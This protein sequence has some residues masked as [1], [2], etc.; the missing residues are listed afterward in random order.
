VETSPEPAE[1]V[2]R[3]SIGRELRRRE[4]KVRRD[5]T[6]I[7]EIAHDLTA[8]S[9]ENQISRLSQGFFAWYRKLIELGA[10]E[11]TAQD[12]VTGLAREWRGVADPSIDD[13]L[14]PLLERFLEGIRMGGTIERREG[15][16][17]RVI[18]VGPPGC[19]KSTTLAK[20]ASEFS[21]KRGV[22]IGI[23]ALD[24][25]RVGA[26]EQISAYA[27]MLDVPLVVAREP[28]E[29]APGLVERAGF[30]RAARLLREI[31]AAEIHLVLSATSTL[32]SQENAIR[33][34]RPL[35]PRR[36][37]L[38][39]LDESGTGWGIHET[40]RRF[41]GRLSYVTFGQSVPEDIIPA[42]PELMGRL[43]RAI[44]GLD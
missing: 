26:V 8:L 14:E 23:L 28:E 3:P 7:Q 36:L 25:H 18:L 22:E 39:K 44:G 2:G 42:E 1:I 24:N 35:R 5:L 30:D 17:S 43:L 37:I 27:R 12:L 40:V 31:E 6:E 10:T 19:G 20:L 4:E 29:I 33:T 13:L 11:S 41:G 21:L 38:T 34:F 9:R 15:K 16:Q 32:V